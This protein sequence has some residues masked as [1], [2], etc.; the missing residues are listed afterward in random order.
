MGETIIKFML[1]FLAQ[2]IA[3]VLTKERINETIDKVLDKLEDEILR[4]KDSYDE[5]VMLVIKG[6]REALGVPD[7]DVVVS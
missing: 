2:A 1:P 3:K 5:A 6:L 7:N 4:D